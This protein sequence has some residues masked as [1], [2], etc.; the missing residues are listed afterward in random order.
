MI[1]GFILLHGDDG[2]CAY[3]GGDFCD[4]SPSQPAVKKL[5]RV[6]S[7]LSRGPEVVCLHPC[8]HVLLEEGK[9]VALSVPHSQL[10]P[11]DVVREVEGFG[12]GA[13]SSARTREPGSGRTRGESK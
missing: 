8:S 7:K 13:F 6:P 4:S 5:L 9:S 10:R 1:K 12:G 2:L 11:A 3:S